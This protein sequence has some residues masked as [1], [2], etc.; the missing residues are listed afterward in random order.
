MA[1]RT[2]YQMES[3]LRSVFVPLS[4]AAHADRASVA[5]SP[6]GLELTILMPCLNEAETVALC[7]RKARGFLERSGIAGEVLVADNGSSDESIE[8][9]RHAGARVVRIAQKGYGSA[10]L[11]GLRAAYGRFVIM[12]DA[13]DSY[14]FSQLEAF[15]S[16][17]RAGNTLVMG[18]R[19][20]GGP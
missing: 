7:V 3:T 14:D 19:F 8:L 10:L 5:A 6:S 12:G 4:D 2:P 1:T 18:H 17:L 20:R 16:S 15:V 9:A 13:D 11:G